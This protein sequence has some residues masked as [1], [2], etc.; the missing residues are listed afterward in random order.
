MAGTRSSAWHERP[1]LQHV[2][3]VVAQVSYVDE[4][5][6]RGGLSLGRL[7]ALA[8]GDWN[9]HAPGEGCRS[10]EAPR[11]PMAK[12]E[13]CRRSAA[14]DLLCQ[15]ALRRRR[16]VVAVEPRALPHAGPCAAAAC[17][18]GHGQGSPSEWHARAV[19]FHFPML[20]RIRTKAP[21]LRHMPV[22]L[23]V[24]GSE[25]Y[26]D[27][28]LSRLSPLSQCRGSSTVSCAREQARPLCYLASPTPQKS[29][30]ACQ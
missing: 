24:P 12:P 3:S 14:G 10:Q 9:F 13:M 26:T 20:V 18:T 4:E 7:C 28:R 2:R 11:L 25:F 16:G 19:S 8:L 30:Q 22:P 21:R 1:Q 15:P 27:R 6:E 5:H 23:Q 17:D 29:S